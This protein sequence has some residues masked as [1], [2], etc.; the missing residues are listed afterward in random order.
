MLLFHSLKNL[1]HLVYLSFL[2]LDDLL[3]QLFY[4]R[5]FNICMF[6]C[7]DGRRMV[8]DHGLHILDIANRRL[9]YTDISYLKESGPPALSFIG[10]NGMPSYINVPLKN[11]V[12][13]AGKDNISYRERQVLRLLAEG[14]ASKEI[15]IILGISKETV[16]RHRKNMLHKKG[17]ANTGELVGKAIRQG[18][19]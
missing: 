17:L 12:L 8:R 15:G 7:H 1:L 11:K 13:P 19:I 2:G 6:A 18:W 5:V 16:D 4:F 3:C 10:M 9:T 14:K